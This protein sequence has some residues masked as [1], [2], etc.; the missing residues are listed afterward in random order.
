MFATDHTVFS[1]EPVVLPTSTTLEDTLY[2]NSL[3]LHNVSGNG[4]CFFNAL[5]YQ[6]YGNEEKAHELRLDVV[7]FMRLHFDFYKDSITSDE[8]ESFES[9]LSRMSRS[10]SWASGLE[11]SAASS[12]LQVP[13]KVYVVGDTY[14]EN[15]VMNLEPNPDFKVDTSGTTML[16]EIELK[17]LDYYDLCK[18]LHEI[19]IGNYALTH[20]VGTDSL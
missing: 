8:G 17:C 9:Y 3:R 10:E 1:S 7:A 16:K 13:I 2:Q 15:T 4:E 18:E 11:V 6:L 12:M 19:V 14:G 20:F 5:S